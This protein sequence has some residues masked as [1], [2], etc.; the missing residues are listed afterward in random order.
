MEVEEEE[1]EAGARV[2]KCQIVQTEKISASLHCEGS[3]THLCHF[4]QFWVT[5]LPRHF[6]SRIFDISQLDWRKRLAASADPATTFMGGRG[7]HCIS[8]CD[9]C[10]VL[11]EESYLVEAG[12]FPA[13]THNF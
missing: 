5:S 9:L 11:S 12:T 8:N 2:E 6:L 1:E 3:A 4:F 7:R 10:F 13:F